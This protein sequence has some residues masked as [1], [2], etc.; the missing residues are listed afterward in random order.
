[1]AAGGTTYLNAQLA[2]DP[3]PMYATVSITSNPPGAA[4]YGDGVYKGTTRSGSPL[5]STQ[6]IPGTHTL[7]LTKAGYQD[8]ST[9]GTVVAGKNYDL[10]ITLNP[11]P[12]P[13]TGSITVNSAPTGA[14][15]Y[16]NNLFRGYS[17]LTVD[18]LTPG[19]YTVVLK[20]DGYQDWQSSAT[21][22]AGQTAQISA[23]LIPK[24]AP[25]QAPTPTPGPS[26]ALVVVSLA[27][28]AL[29]FRKFTH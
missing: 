29:L 14:Q 27:G 19:M 22:T 28:I 24:T 16:I 26:P 8:Y 5:V 13:T 11:V 3:Q 25:T 10:A 9:T 23:T 20:L 6:V 7:L 2:S 17:P 15:V 4:V 21:V 1:V 12:N 18:S